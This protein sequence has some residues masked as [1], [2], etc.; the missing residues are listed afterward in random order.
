MPVSG[1]QCH[2]DSAATTTKERENEAARGVAGTNAQSFFKAKRKQTGP[3][4]HDFKGKG[5]LD[6]LEGKRW[7]AVSST[8]SILVVIVPITFLAI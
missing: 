1:E 8:S 4:A 6:S 5:R 2:Q 3:G 7:G